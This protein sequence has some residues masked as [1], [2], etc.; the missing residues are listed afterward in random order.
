METIEARNFEADVLEEA[1]QS[2]S[3]ALMR[4]SIEIDRQLRILLAVVGVLKDYTG[5]NPVLALDLLSKV[6]GVTVSPELRSTVSDFWAVRNSIVHG[7]SRGQDGLA[8]SALDYGLRILRILLSIPRPKRVVRYVDVP[9]YRDGL[10]QHQYSDVW[11]VILESYSAEGKSFGL[12][13]HPSR[14]K[15]VPGEEVTWE[16]DLGGPGWDEAWYANPAKD[17]LVELAWNESLEFR[18]RK[19]SAV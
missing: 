10:C 12:K 5:S 3:V 9:L 19:L 11:G 6:Q 4:L 17:G 1:L 7:Q 8:L 15:Y 2:P 13:I 16:W 18:G 14:L